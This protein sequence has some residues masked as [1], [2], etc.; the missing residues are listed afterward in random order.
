[1]AFWLQRGY[2]EKYISLAE[3]DLLTGALVASAFLTLL[4]IWS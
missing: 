1:M 2:Y 4:T 3:D